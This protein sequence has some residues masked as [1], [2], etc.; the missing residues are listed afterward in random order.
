MVCFENTKMEAKSNRIMQAGWNTAVGMSKDGKK[1]VKIHWIEIQ[2]YDFPL[3][4]KLTIKHCSMC[5]LP[6]RI[7]IEMC[8]FDE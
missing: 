1:G 5:H 3:R 2:V 7:G 8:G 4:H 6:F